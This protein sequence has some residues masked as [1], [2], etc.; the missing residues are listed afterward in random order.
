MKKST[1]LIITVVIAFLM[2][3]YNSGLNIKNLMGNS[4]QFNS[5]SKVERIKKLD[6]RI[7]VVYAY[8]DEPMP[9]FL[10]KR[11]SDKSWYSP[12][13]FSNE[14]NNCNEDTHCFSNNVRF[15]NDWGAREAAK[16]GKSF[17]YK[18]DVYKGS[19]EIPYE[20][21]EYRKDDPGFIELRRPGI[22]YEQLFEKYSN[23]KHYKYIS[24]IIYNSAPSHGFNTM[25]TVRYNPENPTLA[26]MNSGWGQFKITHNWVFKMGGV[27]YGPLQEHQKQS[28]LQ[29][30]MHEFF[31]SFGALDKY[32]T[33]GAAACR[34]NPD[35]GEEYDMYD[36]FCHRIP[37]EGGGFW[38]V[39]EIIDLIISAPTAEEIGWK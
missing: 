6:N 11:I 8:I 33:T 10:K 15:I 5:V 30:W 12:T 38:Q 34:I 29:S 32:G 24:I 21:L 14:F 26:W 35:T 22:L 31:H 28:F 18:I 39:D 27:D 19:T 1:Y 9:T 7:A 37:A 16:Y 2:L 17:N 3:N 23:L 25:G 20:A 13:E 36:L 4:Y